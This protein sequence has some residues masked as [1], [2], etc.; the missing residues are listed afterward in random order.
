MKGLRYPLVLG[1]TL[2]ALGAAAAFVILKLKVDA[3]GTAPVAI[4][5]PAP[6]APAPQPPTPASPPPRPT[7]APPASPP[8]PATPETTPLPPPAWHPTP[9]QAL[10]DTVYL[11]TRSGRDAEA[12]VLLDRWIA[13]HPADT[14]ALRES[15]RLLIRTGRT[16]EGLGRYRALLAQ[17]SAE[18]T[19]AEYAGA[20]I[21]A[22]RYDAAADEYQRLLAADPTNRDYRLGRGRALA[23]GGHPREAAAELAQAVAPRDSATELLLHAVR[24]DYEPRAAEA[25]AW[26]RE[27]PDEPEYR[28]ALARALAREG[29]A[30]PARAQYDTLL[31]H[32]PSLAL[33]R[34]AAGASAM[35][36]DSLGAARLLGEAV[37]LAP[38]DTLLRRDYAR[39][40][41]WSGDR[42][43]AIREYSVLLERSRDPDLLEA[44]GQ[45]HLWA[46]NDRAAEAD[47]RAAADARPTYETDMMLGDLYRWRGD[48]P[49]AVAAYQDALRRKPGDPTALA[50]LQ[51]TKRNARSRRIP[52]DDEG[53]AST[54]RFVADNA[55]FDFVASE[56]SGGVGLGDRN[57]T[58]LFASADVRRVSR[59]TAGLAGPRHVDGYWVQGGVAQWLGHFRASARAGLLHHTDVPD[60][61]TWAFKAEL[62]Q[63]NL[64]LGAVVSRSA[65]Y[66]TLR[67]GRTLGLAV[68]PGVDPAVRAT[69]LSGS[70]SLPLGSGADLWASAEH[71]WL[72]DDNDRTSVTLAVRYPLVSGL[73]A[74]YSGGGL[75]FGDLNPLYW[76]PRHYVLQALG[77]EYRIERPSGFRLALRGL[78]GVAFLSERTVPGGPAAS[79]SV[80]QWSATLD[81]A[82]RRP[83]WELGVFGAYGRD[84]SDAGY[85]AG[86]G[87]A[88]LRWYW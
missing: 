1:L 30:D 75:G 2:A 26:V 32:G 34:E 14:S 86:S 52:D 12:A 84:R 74:V 15:A 3:V 49:R 4:G 25:A 57:R 46:G 60:I 85:E 51:A 22:G 58:I 39:G 13:R 28:L 54:T 66:E 68:A 87:L 65:A 50:G 16:A 67:A 59:D 56:L 6:P 70:I 71:L 8:T 17:D 23:W 73:S 31:M 83:R 24:R 78:P 29:H 62:I 11:L 43:G 7:S 37:A 72:S 10:R 40:L 21:A 44:R 63:P 81:L 53:F 88:R 9:D 82:Y 18:A 27:Q 19:R 80:F 41:A 45:L 48:A 61:G 33:I 79:R 76:S 69:A 36:R 55:G 20:L 5:T 47:L 77:L 38:S 64:R 35:A 42:P